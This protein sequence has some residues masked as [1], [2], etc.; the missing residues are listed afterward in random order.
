MGRQRERA[1]AQDR[2]KRFRLR[3]KA[4]EGSARIAYP[5]QLVDMLFETRWL[6]PDKADTSSAATRIRN[7]LSSA[8]I[9]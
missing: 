3:Q 9:R 7:R 4:G 2:L 8:K 6:A 1:L 5:A